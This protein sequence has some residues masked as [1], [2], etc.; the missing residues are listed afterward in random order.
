MRRLSYE[1]TVRFHGHDGPFLALGY[2]AGEYAVERLRPEGLMD[3]ECSVETIA[4]KPYVCVMDGIQ[5]ST[6]CTVGKANLR[7]S[8]TSRSEISIAFRNR[9]T[10]E[11]IV[12]ILRPDILDRALKAEDLPKEAE[13]IRAKPPESLFEIESPQYGT[14]G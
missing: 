4:S 14:T 11:E 1:E 8:K 9:K 5:G 3:I 12:L 13:W 6:P 7:L 10:D 2:R